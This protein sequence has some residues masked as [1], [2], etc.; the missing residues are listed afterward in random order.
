ML[1]LITQK[2]QAT[3]PVPPALLRCHSLPAESLRPQSWS[4]AEEFSSVPVSSLPKQYLCIELPG[5]FCF[6]FLQDLSIVPESPLLGLV[7]VVVDHHHLPHLQLVP[8]EDGPGPGAHV[9]GAHLH[10]AV[11]W[12]TAGKQGQGHGQQLSQEHSDAHRFIL[13]CGTTITA[14]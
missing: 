4:R 2:G 3:F 9:A 7:R 13:L 14:K 10:H 6:P 1:W 12:V 8:F 11:L 5:E